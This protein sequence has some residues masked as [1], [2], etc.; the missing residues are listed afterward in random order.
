MINHVRN[1]VLTILNKENR[2]YITP[3][4]FNLYARHAQRLVFDHMFARYANMTLAKNKRMTALD[5]GDRAAIDRYT[6]DKFVV[7]TTIPR[8]NSQYSKPTDLY[9]LLRVNL[10][11]A[12][13][14]SLVEYLPSHKRYYIENNAVAKPSSL[15]PYYIEE[16]T[17]YKLLPT[18][19]TDDLKVT[20][21]RHPKDPKW[22]YNTVGES[23]VYNASASDHQDFEIDETYE[24]E[25]VYEI[26]KLSG[27]TIGEAAITQAAVALDQQEEQKSNR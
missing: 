21:V 19:L 2:G 1:I 9:H 16:G 23:P 24:T 10:D 8:S 25:I 13:N 22:T 4:Q 7:T 11:D 26:L 20:Y 14:D 15:Y 5:F 6:I 17:K 12:T 27:L 3:E 18:D